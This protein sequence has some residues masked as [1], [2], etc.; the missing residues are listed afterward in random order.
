MADSTMTPTGSAR[1]ERPVTSIG[2]VVAGIG[3]LVM[4]ILLPGEWYDALPKNPELP[5]AQV[6]GLTLLR[7]SIAVEALVLI[8]M[9]RRFNQWTPRAIGDLSATPRH[10]TAERVSQ[11]V[12]LAWLGGIALLGL[13]LR[14]WHLEADLWLDEIA[15][16]MAYA[17]LSPLQVLA[18]Y[19]GSNNHLLNTLLVKLSVSTFGQ[20]EWSIRLPAVL[21]G[22]ATIPAFYWTARIVLTRTS[23]LAAALLLAVSYHHVFF[24]QNARG[25]TAYMFFSLL[26]SGLLCKA[27]D[28]GRFRTWALYA[29]TMLLNMASL[30]ISGFVL[31]SHLLVGLGVVVACRRALRPLSTVVPT[32]AGVFAV[33]G[34]LVFQLYALVIPQAYVVMKSVYS[35]SASGYSL[36]S[37]DFVNELL[38]GVLVAFGGAGGWR[39]VP[40]LMIGMAVGG[41]SFIRLA[42]RHPALLAALALPG[43]LTAGAVLLGSLSVSPRFFLLSLPLAILVAVEALE[44]IADFVWRRFARRLALPPAWLTFGV[45][46]AISAL[47]LVPLF[48]YY[49][50][51]PKQPYTASAAFVQQQQQPGDLV[52]VVHLAEKGYLYYGP[53]FGLQPG[54]DS[55]YLRSA[56]AL[57]DVM[58]ASP[59]RRIILVST[60]PRALRLD[61]PDLAALMREHWTVAK[62]F[63]ATIGDGDISVWTPK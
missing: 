1:D 29:G 50:V 20:Q 48:G 57:R 36:A 19:L 60:F 49:Y 61:F 46:A 13:V 14:L 53:R 21:F 15:P 30:L 6:S 40:V 32:L 52:V 9:S 37:G 5:V 10:I 11:P 39:I 54:P 43:V 4:A 23:S 22:A 34:F 47:L 25:Y 18:T 42:K 45:S 28:D 16:L 51:V 33:T 56:E 31:A 44:A 26:S 59:G 38:R 24:S 58:R 2:L 7:W 63:P 12:A 17:P 3:L 27:L 62:V 35:K 41:Y 55:I 8:G